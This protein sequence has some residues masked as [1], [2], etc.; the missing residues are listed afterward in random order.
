M[1]AVL[2]I[3]PFEMVNVQHQQRQRGFAQFC[4]GE[5]LA[6][7]TSFPAMFTSLYRTG[8]VSGQLDDT[9]KRLHEYSRIEG[10]RQM[11][12]F[13]KSMTIAIILTIMVAIGMQVVLFWVGYF[14]NIGNM[15][16][17]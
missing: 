6:D 14:N 8:E 17:Q 1:V 15:L 2:V 10:H 13:T 9:L 3:D 7:T 4:P 12:M 16:S 5:L 11:Q